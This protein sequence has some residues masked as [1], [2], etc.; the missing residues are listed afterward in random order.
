MVKKA[1]Q[2]RP[3]ENETRRHERPDKKRIKRKG[4]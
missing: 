1:Q 3:K 2:R 4:E